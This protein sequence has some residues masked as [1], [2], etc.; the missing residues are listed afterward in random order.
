MLSIMSN[1]ANDDHNASTV[2]LSGVKNTS[3][4]LNG[5][6]SGGARLLDVEIDCEVPS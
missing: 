5:N 6:V 2:P 1:V 3:Y 4:V